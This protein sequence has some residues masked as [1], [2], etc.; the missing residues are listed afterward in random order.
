MK[1]LLI[2]TIFGGIVFNITACKPKKDNTPIVIVVPDKPKVEEPVIDPFKTTSCGENQ[3]MDD[4]TKLGWTNIW[5]DEFDTDLN[6]WKKW[7]GGAFNSEYQYYN[8]ERNI[9]LY[10]GIMKITPKMEPI[11]GVENPFSTTEK[12][13][14]FTSARIESGM[15]FKPNGPN[16]TSLRFSARIRAATGVG[17]AN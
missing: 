13:F 14:N 8:G 5:K 1:N 15:K 9:T 12:N 7:I 16:Y 3:T 11:R 2:F 17:M 6:N 4:L 10:E